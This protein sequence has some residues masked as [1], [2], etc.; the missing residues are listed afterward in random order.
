M[1]K[2]RFAD[3]SDLGE[4]Y[5]EL[6]K[7][8]HGTEPMNELFDIEGDWNKERARLYKKLYKGIGNTCY[9][10]LRLPNN[11][12]LR[13]KTEY[14]NPMGNSHYSRFWLPYL[15]LAEVTGQIAPDKNKLLEI[16]SGN[17]GI[18]LA[19][20]ARELGYDLT[21]LVPESLPYKGRVEPMEKRGAKVV[22]V[23]GY[24]K[25]CMGQL[26][27]MLVMDKDYF[28]LNHSEENG[29]VLVHIMKRIAGEY[30][31]DFGTPDYVISGIGNGTSTM[32]LYEYF[33]ERHTKI[34]GYYPFEKKD[35]VLGLYVEET[36]LRHV[37]E[38]KAICEKLLDT[39]E[40]DLNKIKER[41]NHNTELK[42]LGPSSLYAIG[43]ALKMAGETEGKSY[44]SLGYD[45]IDRYEP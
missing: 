9:N 6:E 4:K 22:K 28:A 17:S 16:T 5:P 42:N 25:E 43:I 31:R 20:A 33:K 12:I 27:R 38:A 11:N 7:F 34:I 45:K 36:K 3:F 35:I 40:L 23:K 14:T 32:A 18:A 19:M 44:F 8:I 29:N 37:P 41:I 26:K 15:F 24:V 30:D 39:N 1:K 21:I 10:T 13:V 2:K